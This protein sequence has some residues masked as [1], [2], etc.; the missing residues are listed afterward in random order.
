MVVVGPIPVPIPVRPTRL[1]DHASRPIVAGTRDLARDG[2]SA[3]RVAILSTRLCGTLRGCLSAA[4]LVRRLTI[5]L[6]GSLP[7]CLSAAAVVRW[8]TLDGLAP[9]I[10][11]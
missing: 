6:C 1:N 5:R 4:T 7:R 8:A 3:R 11:G 9:I 10:L 2:E